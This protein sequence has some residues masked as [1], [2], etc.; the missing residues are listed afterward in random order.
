MPDELYHFGVKGM[1]WGHRKARPAVVTSSRP[2]AAAKPD[3]N[4]PEYQA[5]VA[6]VKTAAKVGAAVVGT[7][8]AAYG[9]YKLA[10][11]V[12]GQREQAAIDRANEYVSKNFLRT[13][14]DSRFADGTR[15]LEFHDRLGNE[16]VT[17]RYTGHNNAVTKSVGKHNAKVIATGRKM[18]EDGTNT[19]LDR[20]LARITNAGDAVGNAAKKAANTTKTAANKAKN[21]V[22]DVVNPIYEYTPGATTTRTRTT[23]SGLKI[24]ESVTNYYKKKVR[25]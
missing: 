4:S 15:R 21:K 9:T 25:R 6:K 7:A 2:R 12:Q 1:K 3:K 10:K 22:L 17:P 14:G 24:S 13:M 20:G 16:I 5:K 11:Y 23:D 8:L 18:I 19:R